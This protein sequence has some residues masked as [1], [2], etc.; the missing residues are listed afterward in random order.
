MRIRV[1]LHRDVIRFIRRECSAKE[2]NAFHEEL[3]RLR[4]DAFALIENSEP[5]YQPEESR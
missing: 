4:S 1:E 2:R 3:E 5:T